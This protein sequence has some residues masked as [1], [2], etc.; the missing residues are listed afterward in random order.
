MSPFRFTLR[1][2][3][4]F[5]VAIFWRTAPPANAETPEGKTPESPAA[6]VAHWLELHRTGERGKASDLTTGSIDHRAR[7][8]LSSKRDTGVR[9]YQSLG[10]HRA[11]AV[12]TGAIK[13]GSETVLLFWL[14][15]RND[16]WLINKSNSAKRSVVDDRLR[17][18]IEAGDVVWHVQPSDLTGHWD[19]G[20]CYSPAGGGLACGS[21]L[22]LGVDKTFQL[23][24]YGPGGL[25]PAS[26]MKG[27]WRLADDRIQL[28]QGDRTHQ[29]KVVWMAKDVL[30]LKSLDGKDAGQYERI[31]AEDWAHGE[32]EGL[33][34]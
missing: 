2:V 11:A 5:L 4:F 24:I 34:P 15:R 3:V 29:C 21:Q 25:V 16:S 23:A 32:V 26:G 14:I 6:V 9:V 22:Q 1:A 20:P 12:T 13:P 18:F 30:H 7:Y 10:N 27:T 8:L 31:S 28:S 33:N 19:A 17:G